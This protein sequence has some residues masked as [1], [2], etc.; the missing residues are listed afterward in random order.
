MKIIT[1]SWDDGHPADHRIAELLDKY[2][3]PGT[4]YIPLTNQEHDVMPESEIVSLSKKFEIG[5]HTVNHIRINKVS[6]ELFDA[7]IKGS[8]VW[9]K[10]LLGEAPTSF[11]FPGGIYNK[12]AVDYAIQTGFKIIRTTELLNPW[13][14]KNELL[15]PTTLQVY[16]HSSFTYYKHLVKRVKINSLLLYMKSGNVSDLQKLLKYYLD[17]V[18]EHGGCFHLWGHSWEIEENN[19]WHTLEDM[20]NALSDIEGMTYI[21]NKDLWTCKNKLS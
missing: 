3:L 8:Y 16:P 19:L 12:E 21:N 17:Y 18:Q 10:Q 6:N 15:V 7:E 20:F 1:T 11:C 4:F 9:L 13:I 5:A 2:H 14:E